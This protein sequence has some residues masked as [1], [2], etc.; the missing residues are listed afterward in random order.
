M[1]MYLYS[2][3]VSMTESVTSQA[4]QDTELSLR[5]AQVTNA[6]DF[7]DIVIKD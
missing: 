6:S 4:L 3:T 5:P 7:L 1:Y 2:V